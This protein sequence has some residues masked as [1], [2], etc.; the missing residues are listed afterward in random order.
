MILFS[1]FH[2][3]AAPP[4]LR[5]PSFVSGSSTVYEERKQKVIP[6]FC[7]LKA[8]SSQAKRA[9]EGGRERTADW[10]KGIITA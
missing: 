7:L 8:S 4:K 6:S 5:Q 3:Q 2:V 9:V 10:A 1:I